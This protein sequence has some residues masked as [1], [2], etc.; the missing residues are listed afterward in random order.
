MLFVWCFA[1][2]AGAAN[3]CLVDAPA[4]AAHLAGH[5]GHGAVPLDAAHDDSWSDPVPP[6]A[7]RQAC[8]SFCSTGQVP[9]AKPPAKQGDFGAGEAACVAGP[10]PD[11]PGPLQLQ[12]G[13]SWRP[14]TALP[15][16][17]PAVAIVFRRQNR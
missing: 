11:W 10:H 2:A 17:G 3:A 5:H 14:P 13:Q 1:L 9:V 4:A 6:D 7:A 15:P 12:P 8:E 16:A